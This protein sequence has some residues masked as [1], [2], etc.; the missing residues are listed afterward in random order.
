MGVFVA[1][2]A[3]KST[4]FILTQMNCCAFVLLVLPLITNSLTVTTVTAEKK[5]T[6]TVQGAIWTILVQ[7]SVIFTMC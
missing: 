7:I 4:I 2:A 3:H 6:Q 1:V 5:V